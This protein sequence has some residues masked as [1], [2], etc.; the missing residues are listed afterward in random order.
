M[1]FDRD[2]FQGYMWV[3]SE[4][5]D[6]FAEARLSIKDCL[7][8]FHFAPDPLLGQRKKQVPVMSM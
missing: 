1:T 2:S 5:A 4:E 3:L 6:R 8:T 7:V